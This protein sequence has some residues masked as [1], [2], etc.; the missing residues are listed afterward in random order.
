VN[1][2]I[3]PASYSAGNPSCLPCLCRTC[4]QPL[5]PDQAESVVFFVAQHGTTPGRCLRCSIEELELLAWLGREC[6]DDAGEDWENERHEELIPDLLPEN[7]APAV[8]PPLVHSSAPLL[9]RRSLHPP[10][11]VSPP[12]H[13]SLSPLRSPVLARR[14]S[15]EKALEQNTPAPSLEIYRGRT[16]EEGDLIGI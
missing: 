7:A 10:L 2:T 8:A 5:A 3:I 13:R 11:L 1:D 15:K 9:S 12:L 14:R 16:S 6:W 4:E